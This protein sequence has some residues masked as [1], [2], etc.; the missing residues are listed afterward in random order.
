[1][2]GP[3]GDTILKIDGIT[4]IYPGVRALDQVSFE[5]KR[6]EV[7]A[8]MGENGAGKSTLIKVISGAVR[9]ESGSIWIDG[10]QIGHLTPALSMQKGIGVIYQ[11]F[12]N[13]PSI[14][15]AH[16]VFLGKRVGGKVMF[17]LKEMNRRT[18][19]IFESLGVSIPVD[20]MVGNLSVA[21]QQ[22]VEIARALS[23][24][25]KVLIMDEPSATLAIA[26]VKRLFDIIR[27]L[28]ERGVTIIYI[29]HRMEE[30]FELADSITV[31]RD[32]CH[33]QTGPMQGLDRK[34][35]IRL[36]VGRELLEEYPQRHTAIG[37]PVLEVEHLTGSGDTDISLT[38]HKGEVLGL[39]GLVGAGRTE[40][41]R[42]IYGVDPKNAGSVKI[43][44]RPVYF[45]SPLD[46]LN[47]GVG[48]ISESRKTEGVFLDFPIDWNITI[49]ALRRY[50]RLTFTDA[51]SLNQVVERMAARFRIKAPTMKQL[52]RNLSGGNQ[53]KVA[54][55]K[56]LALDTDIVIFDEPTR[57]IDVGVKQEIYQII[58][59]M[60]D[61]GISILMISS[62]M[63]ELIGM[64]DRIVVLHEGRV[65]GELRKEEFDQQ[66]ILE[67][68]SGIHHGKAAGNCE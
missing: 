3:S 51:K 16:N 33:V 34:E 63:E 17:N 37:E 54:L 57:G 36:M 49:S 30:V 5:V 28:K 40:L 39:A 47:G 65:S 19:E 22:I 1:M 9:P 26:E 55:A 45:K 60:V 61:K 18:Q 56:V 46:A 12:N 52:V 8:L 32:G 48:Y 50:S 64:S 41:A 2:S 31:L 4:K 25:I 38:L 29:S 11:E 27:K 24:N 62:E 14:S 43:K 66:R 15:V 7:H 10:E 42:M 35:I 20:A 6:G 13:V 59:E 68:A 23:Q 53:Q 67:Y 21:Q 58:N 44:G